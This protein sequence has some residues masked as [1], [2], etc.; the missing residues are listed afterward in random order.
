MDTE[1]EVATPRVYTKKE[2]ALIERH[3][4]INVH[5]EDWHEAVREQVEEELAEIGFD[6]TQMYFS[7]FWSQG[8]GACFEGTM[9]DW[10]KFCEQVPTFVAA[11][12]FLTE[13]IKEQGASYGISHRGRDYHEHCTDHDY[14]SELEWELENLVVDPTDP[15]AQMLQALWTKALAEEGDTS[16]TQDVAVEGWLKEFFQDKMRDLYKRLEQEY[17]YL[18]SDDVVW[19]L[20]EANDLDK[21]DAL[22]LSGDDEED[23]DD[24]AIDEV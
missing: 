4:D 21:Q 3:R 8:D 11:F 13:Y 12:P 24:E 1:T 16:G 23:D 10:G 20:I 18:T 14:S 22:E 15:E 19:E 2:E 5:W 17:N 6:M 7:G 9:S